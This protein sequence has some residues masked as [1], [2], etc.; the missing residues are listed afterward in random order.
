MPIPERAEAIWLLLMILFLITELGTAGL[1]TIWFAAG[2]S[3]AFLLSL[4][5][6]ET[7]WQV[8]IF[9]A[10][11]V[12]LFAFTRPLALKYVNSRRE[13]TNYES[14]IGK[15]VKVTQRVSNP[16]QTG[17]AVSDG[18]EWTARSLEDGIILE[19]G[20]LAVVAKIEGV[21]LILEKKEE[22]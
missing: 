3:A 2:S 22:F 21:K 15:T 4:A 11:S 5:G 18:Q 1:T 19:E 6:V 17:A 7:V 8:G 13:K 16:D 20:T 12:I 10:V 9:M 14:L